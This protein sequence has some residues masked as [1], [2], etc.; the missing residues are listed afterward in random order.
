MTSYRVPALAFFCLSVA[1]IA[2]TW[3][4]SA[5]QPY[6]DGW[7]WF[8]WL[9][10]YRDKEV[11]WPQLLVRT[12]NEHPIGLS[13]LIFLFLDRPFGY[14]LRPLAMGSAIAFI[15]SGGIVGAVLRS[16]GIGT[17]GVIAALLICFSPRSVENLLTGFQITFTLTVLLGLLSIAAAYYAVIKESFALLIVLAALLILGGW[18]TAGFL[19]VYPAIILTFLIRINRVSLAGTV[20]AVGTAACWFIMYR[21]QIVAPHL[22]APGMMERIAGLTV[23]AGSPLVEQ[24]MLAGVIGCFVLVSFGI[25]GALAWLSGNSQRRLAVSV[26]LFSLGLIATIAYGRGLM[27]GINPSR[28]ATFGAPLAAV[29][30]VLPTL[31]VRAASLAAYS[32]ALI[33]FTWNIN[34]AT[35]EAQ[36]VQQMDVLMRDLILNHRTK[37]AADLAVANPAPTELLRRLAAMMEGNLWSAFATK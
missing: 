28:Y 15:L 11:T 2:A 36:R 29:A 22:G 30:L 35:V 27:G 26:G 8:E 31:Y 9:R 12:H 10:Q 14:D 37:S 4:Y 17:A 33:A 16:A 6:W 32:V 25:F 1:V 21:A 5:S 19:A 3:C 18:T 13:T 34:G 7:T 23:L 24:R 20:L